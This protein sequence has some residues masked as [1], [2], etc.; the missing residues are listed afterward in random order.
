MI[1]EDFRVWLIEV[2]SNPYLGT[3][4]DFTKKLVPRMINDMLKI[5]LDPTIKPKIVPDADRPNDFEC[6]YRDACTKFNEQ[7][8]N[9][10]RPFKSQLLY[11]V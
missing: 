7:A 4:N 5:V 10:R 2:N 3:P 1:D 8:I 9:Q 6:V 11:P